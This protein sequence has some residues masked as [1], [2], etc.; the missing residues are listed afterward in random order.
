MN[1]GDFRHVA[2]EVKHAWKN[3]SDE[4]AVAIIATTPRLGRFFQ[5]AGRPVPPD[6]SP[7]AP[8][9][10]MFNVSLRSQLAATIGW[11]AQKK[12]RPLGSTYPRNIVRNFDF[13]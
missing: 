8:S 9:P 12:T 1:A 11:P 3:E 7:Q 4:P 13:V 6:A 2:S 5:E 10:R